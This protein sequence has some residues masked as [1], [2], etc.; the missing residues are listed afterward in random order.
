[1]TEFYPKK[2]PCYEIALHVLENSNDIV[3]SD[4]IS[5]LRKIAERSSRVTSELIFSQIYSIFSICDDW[6]EFQK[7]L[8]ELEKKWDRRHANK[9]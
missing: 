1:M 5:T 3:E 2:Y 4:S 6:E 7:M 8:R 9:Q